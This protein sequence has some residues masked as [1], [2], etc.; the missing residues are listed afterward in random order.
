MA[1]NSVGQAYGILK[2]RI[3]GNPRE[4]K[5]F[6]NSMSRSER[7]LRNRHESHTRV[8]AKKRRR[9]MGQKVDY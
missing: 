2:A 6:L 7:V 1:V 9:P 3:Q 8:K 4:A 5:R